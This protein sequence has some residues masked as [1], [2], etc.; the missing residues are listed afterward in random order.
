MNK[1]R[2]LPMFHLRHLTIYVSMDDKGLPLFF[3]PHSEFNFSPSHAA[4]DD[5]RRERVM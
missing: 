1:S 3:H 2:L 5:A 4:D